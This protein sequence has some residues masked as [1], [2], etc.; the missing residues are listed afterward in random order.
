MT[1]RRENRTGGPDTEKK[2]YDWRKG[3][4]W[5]KYDA[6]RDECWMGLFWVADHLE[7]TEEEMEWWKSALKEIKN[8][9]QKL[10]S[11]LSYLSHPELGRII[12][13]T[14]LKRVEIFEKEGIWSVKYGRID[15]VEDES[16]EQCKGYNVIVKEMA[17]RILQGNVPTEEELGKKI[18]FDEDT[19]HDSLIWH[20]MIQ[21][22]RDIA[23][24]PYIGMLEREEAEKAFSAYF[25]DKAARLKSQE[26]G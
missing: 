13:L 9:I 17:E 11:T 18:Y 10:G 26:S 5:L 21:N 24:L 20:H 12:A 15:P 7:P 4:E 6:E 22:N 25:K 3:R 2:D 8:N 19:S 16:L 23:A 14:N 1:D